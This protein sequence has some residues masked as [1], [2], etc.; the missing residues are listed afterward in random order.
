MSVYTSVNIKELKI[1]LQDY[2]FDDLTDYQ[3]I[4][5]GITNTNYFLMTAHDRFVLTLFEK[6]TIEDLPYFVDLM[7]HLA[8]HS[9]LCPKPILKKNGTALS[10]LKNKPALIVTC[11]KGKEITNPE[12]N[13]CKAVG[14]SLAELHVKSANFVA[15][16]QNT[17]DLS[18]IK[19]TAET[20]FNELPQDES[21]LLREEIFYQEKQNYKLPKSTIHGDL[22]KDNVLFLNDEVS[23][24]IDFYYACTDYLILDVAIA[25]NDWCV[26]SDGS[27]DES[28]LNAFLDAYKKIRSFNDNEDRAWNDVLRLASL[29]FWVSRLNDFYHAEEGELTFIKD[30]NH[31][32]KILKKRISG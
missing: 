3:G 30:P 31:F 23:G 25:V 9:F 21:K 32:K 24:F 16:H 19:K 15:Q 27:F 13:H 18:W 2:A 1:W 26:N 22:F 11:L 6:N 28:R 5:S 17:R 7:S 4:K 14:K 12:V 8:T 20:L 29:R 10:I